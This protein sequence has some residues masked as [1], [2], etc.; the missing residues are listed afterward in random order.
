M[1]KRRKLGQEMAFGKI[2]AFCKYELYIERYRSAAE[3]ARAELPRRDSLS[4]LDVGS[5]RGRLKY[6]FDF[7]D[8]ID[9]HGIEVLDEMMRICSDIGYTMHR[10]D[11]DQA[12]LPFADESFDLVA[13]LHVLEHLAD[14]GKAIAEMARV[15]RPGGLLV[16]GVPTKPPLVAESIGL[17]YALRQALRPT[18]GRTCNAYSASNFAAF[19][20]RRLGNA[21]TLV[22]LRGFRLFSARRRLPLE[23]YRWFYE[24]STWFGRRAPG[25]TPEI[26]AILRKQPA[27][28]PA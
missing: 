19:L 11:I 28:Q 26:N 21:F 10:H 12:A 5:G 20:R 8:R 17:Y 13:G 3:I 24:A 2:P 23:N 18:A 6:F 9:W 27:S 7:H 4:V 15:L 16:L 1:L 14:P 22:D 25:L